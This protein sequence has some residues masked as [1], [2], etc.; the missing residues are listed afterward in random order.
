MFRIRRVF[1]D[2]SPANQQALLQ[3]RRILEEQF[4]QLSRE[5]IDK[6][7]DLLR[8]PVKHQFK[9][10][11]YL[12]EGRQGDLKGFALLSHEPDLAFCFLDYVAADPKFSGRGV[13]G[14]LYQHVREEALLLG[15]KG[16]FFECLP[17]EPAL[18]RDPHTLKANCARLRFYEPYGARPIANTAYETP[19]TENGDNPP[20]LVFDDL[21]Q[22]LPLARDYARQVVRCIL[23][24]KYKD[25]C[26]PHYNRMVI[27]SF[28]DDP[29]RLR[30]PRYTRKLKPET[31]HVS[32]RLRR[33][34][35]VVTDCHEI[36]HV[37]DRGYVEAPVRLRSILG[38]LQPTGLFESVPPH[39]YPDTQLFAL[40]DPKYVGYFRKVCTTLAPGQSVYPYV[41][42]IRNAT[43]PPVE[44][45][46]RA[47]YYCIDTFTPLNGNAFTAAKRAVACAITAAD[48]VLEGFRVAYALVRPPGHHAERA[49][50]GGFCYF[51]N[52]AAAAHHLSRFGKVAMLDIDYHH[53]N[54]QQMIFYQRRDI[55]TLSIHGHPSF[56]YPYFSGFANETGS[57]DGQGFNH[58]Y[59]L[60]ETIDAEKYLETVKKALAA[61]RA[62]RP[63]YLV[64]CLGLDTAKGDPT[65]TWP[66]R[67]NDFHSLGQLV[68][69]IPDPIV[70][71][72]EGGYANRSLGTNAR[73]FF[74]GLWQAKCANHH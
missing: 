36:H 70:V 72:Q 39:D 25:D 29:V 6:I 22:N 68:G 56:A 73:Q 14:A 48:L 11:I 31:I 62:F 12:A 24:R 15:A 51:N 57:G 42:P 19:I 34:A 59:P 35:L 60:P 30:P 66:L 38:A 69:S 8:N 13:G 47:G 53:G 67:G 44:M 33:I 74:S 17:D 10:I 49:V 63:T 58:N 23:E 3:V 41:F 61:I 4:V 65:G 46:V 45:A 32:D 5:R 54:G 43:R 52:A 21:G 16:I 27:D 7:P 28:T 40:H 37:H 2:Y 1:D 20:Y 50:F 26:S 71:V 55:L 9:S 64:L 18:C